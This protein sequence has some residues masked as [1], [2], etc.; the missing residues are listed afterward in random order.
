MRHAYLILAHDNF[1]FLQIL[2]SLIDD[3][4][5]DIFV[6]IDAKVKELP[7]LETKYSELF[8]IYN[9]I[10]VR[11]GHV[12]Q[13]E[14][15]CNILETAYN[16]NRNYSY[17]HLISGVDLPIKSQDYIHSFFEKYNGK[18]FVGFN[19]SIGLD[20]E[21]TRKVKRY[22]IFDKDFRSNNKAK[23]ILRAIFIKMQ[24]LI[25]FKR[26][27]KIKFQKGTNWFSITG[28]L[29]QEIISNKGKILKMYRNSFCADEIFLHTLAWNGRFMKRF[30]DVE[31]EANGC[32]RE[33]GWKDGELIDFT[34]KDIELL[35][36]SDK[37][38]ARKFDVSD[39]E[40]VSEIIN[41]VKI[42]N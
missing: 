5:N 22:H 4:R 42:Q 30:Y 33:I 39:K 31:N 7:K 3:I 15:E 35:K 23:R 2:I 21:I 28:L 12:S 26:Y 38:F 18:E 1:D 29:A 36:K 24:E 17:Y 25:G 6:H 41:L 10:D 27:R 13:I 19:R 14:C 32:M 40:L 8:I 16:T 9:R 11:W 20:K 37:I 34:I